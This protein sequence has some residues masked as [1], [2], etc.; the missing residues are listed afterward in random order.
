[1]LRSASGT[2]DDPRDIDDGFAIV[3]AINIETIELAAIT[4]VYGNAPLPMSIA[5]RMNSSR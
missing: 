2:K 1:M 4:T 5:S 3:E